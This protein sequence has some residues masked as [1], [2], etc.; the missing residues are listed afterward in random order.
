MPKKSLLACQLVIGVVLA[1]FSPHAFAQCA[2]LPN[3]IVNGQVSDATQIMANENALL[4]CITT[5]Q[6][7]TGVVPGN[8][9]LGT[10]TVDS[11]GRVT[12]A[13]NGLASTNTWT[14]TQNFGPVVGSVSTQVGT[15]YTLSAND[16]GTT[17]RFTA[18]S[19][20]TLTTLNSLPTGCS[21]AVEQAGAGQITVSAGSGTTLV[22]SHG[23]TK[24]YGQYAIL[25]LFV[26]TN[27]SGSSANFILTGDGA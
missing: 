4:D 20:I 1:V 17:V 7:D 27:T 21:V 25:G 15:S 5:G 6:A 13:Q 18:S 14:G 3:Q 11:K 10:I 16:C 19:S 22:S 24:S 2:A 26:D 8:Y 23:F 9:P 12:A